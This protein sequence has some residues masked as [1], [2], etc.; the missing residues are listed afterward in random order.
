[1]SV[2]LASAFTHAAAEESQIEA[3]IFQSKDGGT[4]PYRILKPANYDPGVKYPLVLCLHG[5]AGCGAD[6]TS[7]GTE[8]FTAL[9]APEVRKAYPAFLLTPQC[10]SGKRWVNTP[11]NEG[12]YSTTNIPVSEQMKQVMEILDSVEKEFSIDP[13]RIYV[14]GQSMG[15]YGTWDI[16]LRNPHK[17]AAAVP[18]CG[19]GDPG[20][21][22]SIAHLPVW[23]FHGEK[24]PTVPV[25]GSREMIRALKEAG[26]A[27]R[28]TEYPG[29][30]HSS[31]TPA[32]KD[33]ELIPW[34]FSQRKAVEPVS[35][36]MGK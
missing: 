33:K 19:A 20:Q 31:W 5:A 23:A 16:V 10:P 30:G 21:A 14:T 2:L 9:S 32:W 26:S 29:V 8:A 17:F 18:V 1:M 4:M 25:A 7:R 34:L 35:K 3:R 15:G 28:Y 36:A 12:S 11:W 24:D 27:A 6:N 13:S 22:K